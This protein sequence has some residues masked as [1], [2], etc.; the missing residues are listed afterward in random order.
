MIKKKYKKQFHKLNKYKLVGGVF[1]LSSEEGSS[2][3]ICGFIN[4]VLITYEFYNLK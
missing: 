3:P 1:G 2:Y 4:T